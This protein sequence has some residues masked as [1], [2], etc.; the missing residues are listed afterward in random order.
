MLANGPGDLCSN[1]GRV[2][3]K[4]LKMVL[5][6]SLL[7]TH[8]YKVRIKGKVDQSWEMI[9]LSPIPRC[10]SYWKGSLLV[11]LDYGRYIYL[12]L[13]SLDLNYVEY[14][15]DFPMTLSS[16]TIQ[17]NI[18][19]LPIEYCTP[20][21]WIH[22]YMSRKSYSLSCSVYIVTQPLLIFRM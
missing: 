4:T 3:P 20:V 12:L 15:L 5:D 21:F 22:T 11:A 8:H 19:E 14:C 1:P 2:I 17:I 9:T 16:Q 6:T 13:A 18:T 10:S 7:N